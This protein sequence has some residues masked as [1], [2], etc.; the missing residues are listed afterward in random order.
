MNLN[1]EN[2]KAFKVSDI[3]EIRNGKGITIEEIEFN[4]GDFTVVQSGEENNGCLGK[5]DKQYCI[6]MN[7]TM[8][9]LPCLTVARTGSAGFV[10]YQK[11]G[12]VVGDSAKILSL[13][14]KEHLNDN[15]MLFLQTILLRNRY[16]YTYGR[17]VTEEK[18]ANEIIMLPVTIHGNPDYDFMNN[19]IKSIKSKPLTTK[20]FKNIIE[21]PNTH[22]WKEFRL[23]DLFTIKKAYAYNKDTLPESE[24]ISGNY[25][26][27]I[28]RTT[29]DCGCDY[30]ADISSDLKIEEG[31]ALTIGGE[32][33]TC[34]YQSENFV[35]GTNV[36]VLRSEYIN[37][38]TGL[39]IC[40][41]IN[42]YS[43]GRFN[44]GR[45]FNKGQIEK[46]I[47]KLPVSISGN[48]DWVFMENYIKTLPY[49]D[50]L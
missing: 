11:N 35:C 49:G 9:E 45:A 7:Y 17:K 36:T 28:T 13:K 5:I 34:F 42:H 10:S 43:K 14:E 24:G 30:I 29:V 15:V 2:Y 8:S 26:R 37:K 19:Y 44:Y 22:E 27:C 46:S 48:P 21:N 25:I 33:I 47:I 50:K 20:N 40:T 3:F 32:G 41:V 18:Y 12:C 38:Y 4:P 1:I 31:N 16:K 39:F 6:D 23:S